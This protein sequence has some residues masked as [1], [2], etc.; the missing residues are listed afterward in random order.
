VENNL[1]TI[2]EVLKEPD[3]YLR[4]GFTNPEEVLECAIVA[5]VDFSFDC[6]QH[7]LAFFCHFLISSQIKFIFCGHCYNITSSQDYK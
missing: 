4:A 5:L 2:L 6:I 3:S 1:R 7:G